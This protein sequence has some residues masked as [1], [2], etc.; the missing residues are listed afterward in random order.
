MPTGSPNKYA[1]KCKGVSKDLGSGCGMTSDTEQDYNKWADSTHGYTDI[2][3]ERVSGPMVLGGGMFTQQPSQTAVVAAQPGQPTCPPCTCE[4]CPPAPPAMPPLTSGAGG[5]PTLPRG[6]VHGLMGRLQLDDPYIVTAGVAPSLCIDVGAHLGW[7][8]EQVAVHGHRVYAFEPFAGN[9]AALKK[10][11]EQYP[12]VRVFEGAVSDVAGEVSFGGG[13]TVAKTAEGAGEYAKTAFAGSSSNNL[14]SKGG[15]GPK[16]R[17]YRLDDEVGDTDA[18]LFLKIDVQGFEMD[19][20]KGAEKLIRDPERR[21]K[22]ILAEFLS[23]Q[24]I[25]LI[26]YLEERDYF[27]FDMSIVRRHHPPLV[28]M[29]LRP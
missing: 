25:K 8:V 18:V 17:S 9:H 20:L 28:G 2:V 19:V 24:T 11:V 1:K 22:Y 5:T 29:M 13:S 15:G 23:T 4:P 26:E 14:I 16:V 7:T 21:P 10:A 6:V 12:G 27:C 3:C